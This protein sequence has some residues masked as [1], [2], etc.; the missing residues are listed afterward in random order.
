VVVTVFKI[1]ASTLCV[2]G[3]VRFPPS[4]PFSLAP[5]AWW[6]LGWSSRLARR[7][8]A[9]R[10]RHRFPRSVADAPSVAARSRTAS[11]RH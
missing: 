4:P 6:R 5:L 2:V 11:R 1:V 3:W 9:R 10:D 7:A 8:T